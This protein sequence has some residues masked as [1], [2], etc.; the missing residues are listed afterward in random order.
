MSLGVKIILT[1]VVCFVLFAVG[2]VGLGVYLWS[3]HSG[4]MLEATRKQTEQG[5]AFGRQTD[6]VGCQDEAITRYKDNRGLSGSM[7]S[8]MFVQACWRTSRPTAGFC[9]GVPSPFDVLRAGRWQ[10]EQAR[11]AGIGIND[12]FGRQIFGQKQAFCDAKSRR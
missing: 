11:R 2:A 1:V 4:P 9:D 5:W 7:A 6:E 8:A 3:R 10:T 12:P